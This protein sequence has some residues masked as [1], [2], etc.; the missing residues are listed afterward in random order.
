MIGTWSKPILTAGEVYPIHV[1]DTLKINYFKSFL[2]SA[3]AAGVSVFVFVS[4]VYVKFSGASPYKLAAE[5]C[6]QQNVPF[7]DFSQ[8]DFFLAHRE[9]FKDQWHLNKE[10]AEIYTSMV[11]SVIKSK[12]SIGDSII[13][14]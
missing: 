8:S 10:G 2:N 12:I 5:I 9:Y 7:I 4:P 6:R 3:K 14:D 11:A 1:V 13:I